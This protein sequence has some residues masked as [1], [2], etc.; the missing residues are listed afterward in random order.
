ME[1]HFIIE[2]PGSSLFFHYIYVR[3][4]FALLRRAGLKAWEHQTKKSNDKS[5]A[6]FDL[7]GVFSRHH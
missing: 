2:Q 4:A 5:I 1:G 6:F 7:F 3:E